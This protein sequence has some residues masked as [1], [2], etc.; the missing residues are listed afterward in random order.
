MR[1]EEVNWVLEASD[2]LRVPVIVWHRSSEKFYLVDEDTWS[3]G[4]EVSPEVFL[5]MRA[6]GLLPE[7]PDPDLAIDGNHAWPI[8]LR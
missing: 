4:P 6:Q 7:R 2:E 5:A 1:L 3:C 8:K